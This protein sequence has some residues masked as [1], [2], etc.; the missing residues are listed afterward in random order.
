MFVGMMLMSAMFTLD[1]PEFVSA[2]KADLAAGKSWTYVGSQPPPENGV[3]IP[4][5]SLTTG[6]DIVLFVTK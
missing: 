4:V 1:N 6:E 5:S 2:V 3:A